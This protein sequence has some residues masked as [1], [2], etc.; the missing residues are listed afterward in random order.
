MTLDLF[1]PEHTAF[2]LHDCILGPCS[3][4]SGSS[5]TEEEPSVLQAANTMY[6]RMSTHHL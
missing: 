6:A 1:T 3:N 4:T 2:S 5:S